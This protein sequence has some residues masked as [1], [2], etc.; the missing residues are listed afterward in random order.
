MTD[1]PQLGPAG[2]ITLWVLGAA[3]FLDI[4]FLPYYMFMQYAADATVRNT[5]LGATASIFLLL[6]LATAF[7]PLKTKQ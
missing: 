6:W 3:L 2:R 5:V 7:G 4:A 1:T